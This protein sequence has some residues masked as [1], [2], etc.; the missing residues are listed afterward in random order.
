MK[1]LI[2]TLMGCLIFGASVGSIVERQGPANTEGWNLAAVVP[3]T[4]ARFIR[5]PLSF[6]PNEGQLDKN[7]IYYVAGRDTCIYFGSTGISISLMR[8]TAPENAASDYRK[9]G[10]FLRDKRD[11]TVRWTIKL[12]FIGAAEE[13]ILSG[14]GT[15]D[16]VIS[17]FKGNPSEWKSGLPAYS[18]IVYK[19][20]WP[21]IDLAY[22]GSTD[23]L[24]Y[25][26]VVQPGVNPSTIRLAYRGTSRVEVNAEGQIEVETPLG[27]FHDQAPLAH[28]V[29]DG[30]RVAIPAAFAMEEPA[31]SSGAFG[32]AV[33]AYDQSLPLVIDPA[34]VISCGFLGGSADDAGA[35][36]AIDGT[37]SI[38]VAGTT[39]SLDFPVEPGLDTTFNGP[40]GGSDAFV[41]KVNPA[42]T[43]LLYCCFLGGAAND[44]CSGVA[45]DPSGNAYITG[46]T[47]S[48]D[49][50][51]SYGPGLTP[52]PNISEFSDAFVTKILFTGTALIFSGFVGGSKTDKALAIAVNDLGDA[53]ITGSTESDDLPDRFYRRQYQGAEDAFVSQIWRDGLAVS[54]SVCIGGLGS[55]IG[56]AI[57][58]DHY[59]NVYITGRTNS[60]PEDGF[61]LV[62]GPSLSY[63]GN[64]DA[65]V[66]NIQSFG[67]EI[68]YCGY[69]GGAGIDGGTGIAIDESGSAYVTGTTDSGAGFPT[70]AGP[71]ASHS[72]GD[73]VFVA[74]VTPA[75]TELVY[76]GFIG[77]VG[78][79]RG[80]AI[81]VDAAGNAYVAGTTDSA[82][83]FPVAG[84]PQVVP[85]GLTDAFVATVRYT[86]ADLMYSGYLGG[87]QDDAA[88]GI[89]A[90]DMGNVFVAGTTRSPDFPV[91]AGPILIPG[92]G[93]GATTDAFV[94]RI[95][96]KLP[97][98]APEDLRFDTVTA[99]DIEI[100]WADPSGR[101]D[102]FR[103]ERKDG[104]NGTWA[105]VGQSNASETTFHET[106]FGEG[107]DHYYRVMA[108]NDIGDSA[109]SAE[110]L[111]WTRPAAPSDLA[112]TVIN[113]REVD[114]FW[115]D[116]SNTESSFAL[117]R[118]LNREDPWLDWQ[119]FAMT[120]ANVTTFRDVYVVEDT[121]YI[122]R[123]R[124]ANLQGYS[125]PA[126]EV[127][128]TTPHLTLPAAPT[129]LQATALDATRVLL[130]WE[131]NAYNESYYKIEQK[132]G[133][134]TWHQLTQHGYPN[135][136][137]EGLAAETMYSFRVRATNNAG[138][139]AY[140]NE[141]LLT[142]PAYQPVLRLP[143]WAVSFGYVDVCTG[144]YKTTFLYNDGYASLVVN[145]V[146]L[147]SGSSDFAYL[148][149]PTPFSIA[150]GEFVEIGIGFL[151][152]GAKSLVSAVFSILSNDP[153]NGSAPF[154][155]TGQGIALAVSAQ[156]QVE[157]GFVRAWIARM[158]YARINAE[159][160]LSAP[161]SAVTFRL[162]RKAGSAPYRG[163]KFFTWDDTV[164]GRWTYTDMFLES[165]ESYAYR[166][167]ALD[168]RGFVIYTSQGTGLAPPSRVQ[169]LEKDPPRRIVK[170]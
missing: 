18:R 147:A 115:V 35:G 26:F 75:G 109:F 21:G 148:G 93:A 157:H 41:A 15:T 137:I 166:I 106:G 30:R 136:M 90:D 81:A 54:Y 111:V 114:L 20:L 60:A 47:F 67:Y 83:G 131:D 59:A 94:A 155:A 89:A 92:D 39:A 119:G 169:R 23:C 161:Q 149:P 52:Q 8:I 91:L 36:V 152:S 25:E 78:N 107:S 86:G 82:I 117:Q 126:N 31:T 132:K 151:P 159:V 16:A 22:S 110:L 100:A 11:Q 68:L 66:A 5:M 99:S 13:A 108:W 46:W 143:I 4:E 87:S 48:Q 57:A 97:P 129:N 58:V 77:G 55:D 105:E 44:V 112:A 24:K 84:G 162:M 1:T 80:M 61:P 163:I 140:S 65:F 33:G 116:H 62:G 146:I 64:Q 120:D 104:E 9:A 164:A 14:D 95:F 133:A 113:E 34:I 170:R 12:D 63:S 144:V 72:G 125:D 167:D 160:A 50:P 7:A 56:T 74:K 6:I 2:K 32:F 49:F 121:T 134:E 29:R 76:S 165:N 128:V 118:K 38:Y 158:D 73:D 135:C 17:Y 88:A 123:V 153:V 168:C 142:T 42:G 127:T 10:L 138:D 103:I 3:R 70:I 96:E 40:P 98:T 79:D 51:V 122:Y 102:G 145:G 37:G 150:P 141:A 43:D 71:C 130:T 19:N 156:L 53:V 101:A 28:Q 45:V 85:S 124:A 139:S 154:T 27:V 69:L